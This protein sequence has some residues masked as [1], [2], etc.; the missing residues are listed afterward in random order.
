M[1]HTMRHTILVLAVMVMA[2]IVWSDTCIGA[3]KSDVENPAYV[4][5]E[6]LVK[7]KP[8]ARAASTE[9]YRT[10]W[11][12]RTLK[13]FNAIG[14]QHVKLPEG[15]TIEAALEIYQDDPNVEYAEP[16]YYRYVDTT[17]NDV[18]YTKLWGL[19]NTG[20][21]VDG[22]TGTPDADID[23]PRAWH[24]NTGSSSVIVA[25]IDT[26][27]DYRHPDLRDNLWTNIEEIPDNGLDDDGNGYVDDVYG[28][29]FVYNDNDPI[30]VNGHG[31]HCAGTIAAKGDNTVGITGICWTA[32][33][34]SLQGFNTNGSGRTSDLI[35]AILYAN[36]MGAHVINNSWGRSS[37]S[38]AERDAICAS[39]AVVVC[40]AGNSGNDNDAQPY[41]PSSY[42]CANIIAVAATDQND[43]LAPFSCYGATSVD[44]AAPGVNIYSTAPG[45]SQL[46]TIWS[47]DFE[48]GNLNSW[49][50]GGTNN[51]WAATTAGSSFGAYS[52]AD[53]PGD[54]NCP[55]QSNTD[56]WVRAPALDLS[57]YNGAQLRFKLRGHSQQG[58]D[59]LYVESSADLFNWT[60][61]RSFHGEIVF[62]GYYIIDLSEHDGK[63][64]VYI[65]FRFYSDSS[66]NCDGWYIDDVIITVL[67]PS[68]DGVYQY[69][70][71]TSMA[72]P[73]VAGIAALIKAYYSDLDNA[74]IKAAIMDNVD[75]KSWLNDKIVSG[76]R[77]NVG[78]AFPEPPTDLPPGPPDPDPP[79]PIDPPPGGGDSSGGGGCFI[80]TTL[81]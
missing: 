81:H 24:T 32:K 76:G 11:N 45:S 63:S 64:E 75:Y 59:Y 14:V 58:H 57:S 38:T 70:E 50:T 4:P 13:T 2:I 35:E 77:A 42:T 8:S 71:G 51:T 80:A 52:L 6:L 54:P 22:T 21:E 27:I 39:L 12:I 29:D 31:T 78:N 41:Y 66:I 7:Y 37:F 73:H 69:M 53:S 19:H 15:M 25:V 10:Q 3:I 48:D 43:Q 49:A 20:Q 33:I 55:Y 17:P 62:W 26:G 46:V 74:R 72:A 34:M 60:E 28:W 23:A 16:N 1:R 18:N 79:D 9:S 5:G 44:V 67:A 30:D 56:S 47:D 68:Y 40:A 65:R 36:R 61:H